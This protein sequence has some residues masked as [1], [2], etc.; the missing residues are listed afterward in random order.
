MTAIIAG[1][2]PSECL[3]NFAKSM[4][5]SNNIAVILSRLCAVHLVCRVDVLFTSW[6]RSSS[7]VLSTIVVGGDGGAEHAGATFTSANPAVDNV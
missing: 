1:A 4:G 7:C 2:I 5:D 3:S 6:L